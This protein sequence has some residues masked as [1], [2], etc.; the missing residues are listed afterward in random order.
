MYPDSRIPKSKR[1]TSTC[2]EIG[3]Y[4]CSRERNHD[5]ACE[6]NGYKWKRGKGHARPFM[7]SRPAWI[8]VASGEAE[9]VAN[10]GEVPVFGRDRLPAGKRWNAPMQVS[11]VTSDAAWSR[12]I[13]EARAYAHL[14]TWVTCDGCEQP[15]SPGDEPQPY[16]KP[17]GTML[18]TIPQFTYTGKAHKGVCQITAEG[19]SGYREVV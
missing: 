7:I 19:K 1:C 2:P 18:G 5:G 9:R 14:V 3:Y 8:E 13:R 12:F 17:T 11:Y 15:F 16:R 10:A 6:A 4:T